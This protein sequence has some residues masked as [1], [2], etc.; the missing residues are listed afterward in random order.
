M[1][2]SLSIYIYIYIHHFETSDQHACN[3][4][5]CAS[6]TLVS[7]LS[8]LRWCWGWVLGTLVNVLLSV[9]KYGLAQVA[10]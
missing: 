6:A 8:Y 9:V 7:T 2:L 5:M 10:T 3:E 1:Y 4:V